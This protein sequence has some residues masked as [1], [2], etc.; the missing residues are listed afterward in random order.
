MAATPLASLIGRVQDAATNGISTI[1][2]AHM[3]DKALPEEHYAIVEDF[4][5]TA[6]VPVV[7]ALAAASNLELTTRYVRHIALNAGVI[8]EVGGIV[9]SEVRAYLVAARSAICTFGMLH[10]HWADNQWREVRAP[11]VGVT[12]DAE[13]TKHAALCE[14]AS[15]VPIA[16]A[17][18]APVLAVLNMF[19]TNH[20]TVGDLLPYSQV[21]IICHI[22]GANPPD[23]QSS[24]HKE[25]TALFRV[26]CHPVSGPWV[27]QHLFRIACANTTGVPDGSLKLPTTVLDAWLS[28]RRPTLPSGVRRLAIFAAAAAIL[29]DDG[30]LPFHTCV[31]DVPKV[32]AAISE[33][34]ADPAKYH[35]GATFYTGAARETR[36]DA[37]IARVETAFPDLAH[38]LVTA[39][40]GAS[41]LQSPVMKASLKTG[42]SATW[43]GIVA[44]W[45]ATATKGISTDLLRTAAE[46]MGSGA[47]VNILN[48]DADNPEEYYTTIPCFLYLSRDLLHKS[49]VHPLT[50]A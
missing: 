32:T 40:R 9:S 7:S 12:V 14:A 48:P 35:I 33:I 30:I 11:A 8:T 18:L 27:L 34:K 43:R 5:P 36:H 29:A 15:K 23:R 20:H 46:C 44:Q 3:A 31:T 24:G 49:N 13:L 16:S 39:E 4:D 42:A 19:N 17:L 41:I 37:L 1:G 50:Q 2:F 26:A 22:A 28:I 45:T 10:Y 6:R 25:I 38:Y 47:Q 21:K